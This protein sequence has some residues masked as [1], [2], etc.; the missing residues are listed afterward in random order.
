MDKQK[1]V[2]TQSEKL[3]FFIRRISELAQTD[4]SGIRIEIE[5]DREEFFSKAKKSLEVETEAYIADAR[6]KEDELIDKERSKRSLERRF[7]LLRIREEFGRELYNKLNIKVKDF[8]KSEVYAEFLMNLAEN[9]YRAAETGIFYISTDDMKYADAIKQRI[10]EK[11]GANAEILEESAIKLGGL[12][13]CNDEGSVMIN[14]TLESRIERALAEIELD[15]I[16]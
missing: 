2:F 16:V 15:D 10:Y 1:V 9:A 12:R 13:S 7:E 3:D 5:K 4:E 8:T 6:S 11:F 14:E